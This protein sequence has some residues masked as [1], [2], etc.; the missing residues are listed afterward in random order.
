[1]RRKN[2]INKKNHFYGNIDIFNSFFFNIFIKKK[3]S[4]FDEY[5]TKEQ[6]YK[7]FIKK[8][9]HSALTSELNYHFY[10]LFFKLL[11]NKNKNIMYNTY[12]N[13]N[14][15]VMSL[16]PSYT[17]KSQFFNNKSLFDDVVSNNKLSGFIINKNFYKDK[18]S[19]NFMFYK[20]HFIGYNFYILKSNFKKYSNV[21]KILDDKEYNS[22]GKVKFFIDGIS[23]K[24]IDLN[25][26]IYYNIF[27]LKILEFYKITIILFI[28]FL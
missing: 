27:L 16:L 9:K 10:L 5:N 18:Y 4:K 11:K 12:I 28:K 21:F 14:R 17:F 3:E 6:L 19:Y 23:E 2:W 22:V 25:S 7:T 24:N 20:K 8:N 15:H 1:M 26:Y 13:N